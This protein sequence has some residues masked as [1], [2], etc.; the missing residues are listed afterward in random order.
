M[1]RPLRPVTEPVN[2]GVVAPSASMSTAT[3]S[4]TAGQATMLGVFTLTMFL[5]AT[6]L[7]MV[8]PLF[9]RMVLPLLGG[10]PS[11][12]NTAMVFF[13]VVLL[14]GYLYAHVSTRWLG[15]R[16][17]ALVHVAV[18]LAPLLV[19]PIAIPGGWSPP[20]EGNPVL[21]LLALLLVAVG[22]PF[23]AVSATSP[24]L[25]AW[26][27]RTGH[28]QAADPY[29][30]YAASNTGSMLALL[31]YPLLIEWHL[32]LSEQRWLWAA[33]Y[34]M[35]TALMLAC[36]VITRRTVGHAAVAQAATQEP[37][38]AVAPLSRG[39]QLRWILLAFIPSSLMLSVTT[40]LS[41]TIAPIPLIWVVPLA[42]YL[43][44]FI[45]VFS[46]RTSALQRACV[47]ALPMVIVLLTLLMAAKLTGLPVL[48][49]HLIAF[50]VAVMVCHG[51]LAADRP[52]TRHLT[53]FYVCMSVGGALGG[54]FNALA[55]PW[56]FSGVTEYPLVLVLLCLVRPGATSLP[57]RGSIDRASGVAL[58]AL[59]AMLVFDIVPAAW[60]LEP[61]VTVLILAVPVV[62]IYRFAHRPM[63]LAAGV[64]A[65]FVAGSMV[66]GSGGG[67]TLHAERTFFG[68]HRVV[69]DAGEHY[70][71]LVHGG[72]LHG[73]Q[74]L[75]PARRREPLTYYT[76][77]GPIGQVFAAYANDPSKQRVAVIGLG[78][79][80]LACYKAAGQQWTF[81]EIDP[82]VERIARD[83]R[84]FTYL[85][86]CA[87]DAPTV[88]GDA[89]LT[90]ANAPMGGYDLIVLDAFS[91][92][93]PP[94]HLLTREALALY[95]DK[96]SPTGVL[97]FHISNLYLDLG[98][99][100]AGLA[101]DAG[102]SAL[103][104]KDRGLLVSE[105]ARGKN[106]S[107]WA[108]M[109]RTPEALA[110]LS[111]NPRWEPLPDHDGL[112]VWTD[113]FSSILSILRR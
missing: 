11:V 24:L 113:D 30:L 81:Y 66:Y 16:R 15:V 94:V 2:S 78:A 36:V 104:Q 73:R 9:A 33:G 34:I 77:S 3:R 14:A 28:K 55:A 51:A 100:V 48:L 41:T 71:S 22:L 61:T 95:L 93:A 18:V 107:Y 44:T 90:L 60:E 38:G 56:L 17:Q 8:Q 82:A 67:R 37:D 98:P 108:A 52:D 43:L 103:A 23:F 54:M 88:I 74:S 7:F 99:V 57:G 65:V 29:F 25:Q 32:H 109:A 84:Y 5:S 106:G 76:S 53:T 72:T 39:R 96:L 13:Q 97:A 112:P 102:L 80:S 85:A 86:D 63:R 21:W 58:C 111:A 50:F 6:L 64:A 46:P 110:P 20:A 49:P 69:V 87:P 62:V 47:R 40:H 26:F 10:S 91:S 31:S 92:D 12:W 83:P 70:H 4:A 1:R 101:H 19:L 35:L 42:L 27:A 68:L 89:R 75:D 79:G 45:L 59:L 105:A